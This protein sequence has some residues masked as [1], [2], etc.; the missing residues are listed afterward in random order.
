MFVDKS[1]ESILFLLFCDVFGQ[2][3]NVYSEMI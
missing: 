1:N 3:L 2:V